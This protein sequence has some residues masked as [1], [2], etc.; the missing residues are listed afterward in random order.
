[1]RRSFAE[2]PQSGGKNG[3]AKRNYAPNPARNSSIYRKTPRVFAFS[4][5]NFALLLFNSHALLPF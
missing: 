3:F 5:F 4:V 2:F 1:L